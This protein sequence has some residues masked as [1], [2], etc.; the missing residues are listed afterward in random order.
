MHNELRAVGAKVLAAS[1]DPLD[2][3]TEVAAQVP[4][5]VAFGV[6]RAQAD[7]LGSW[8]EDERGIVQ[9][10]E[11]IVGSGNKMIDSSYN[12]AAIGRIDPADVVKRINF[13]EA[14]GATRK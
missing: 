13:V 1:V 10:A 6:T 3:A 11:F 5:P 7:Q 4:Y 2:K 14:P 9:Q 12:S 8:W